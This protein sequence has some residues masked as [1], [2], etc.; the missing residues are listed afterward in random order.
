[1]IAFEGPCDCDSSRWRTSSLLLS[2]ASFDQRA[3]IAGAM[4]RV[5]A[6][7]PSLTFRSAERAATPPFRSL[8]TPTIQ[9]LSTSNQICWFAYVTFF[10]SLKVRTK[11]MTCTV[12]GIDYFLTGC[13]RWTRL[14]FDS[15]GWR[16]K[17]R[18]AG[19]TKKLSTK[20]SA[21][22]DIDPP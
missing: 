2:L 15:S 7:L 6:R 8:A 21:H 13:G 4:G 9:H 11:G 3:W 16:I 1:M 17:A 19:I 22:A 10:L 5:R 20:R 18:V 12:C 14:R